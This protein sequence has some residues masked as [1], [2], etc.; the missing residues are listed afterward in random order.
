[1]AKSSSTIQNENELG[2]LQ[3]LSHFQAGSHFL[4][5][6][7]PRFIVISPMTVPVLQTLRATRSAREKGFAVADVLKADL[8][9]A[10]VYIIGVS[11]DASGYAQAFADALFLGIG[12]HLVDVSR[13]LPVFSKTPTF[14]RVFQGLIDYAGVKVPMKMRI[15]SDGSFLV[16]SWMEVSVSKPVATPLTGTIICKLNDECNIIGDGKGFSQSWVVEPKPK[17]DPTFDRNLPF[18]G[19]RYFEMATTTS[20]VKGKV[21]EPNVLINGKREMPF[22]LS[23][24]TNG[25][26]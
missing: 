5:D 3:A 14:I 10:E 24:I 22:D 4:S 19:V 8:Q 18:S 13:S 6:G 16:N 26:F 12:G 11:P 21:F 7:V 23:R 2:F 1:M 20:N 17:N 15:A 25:E 9:R